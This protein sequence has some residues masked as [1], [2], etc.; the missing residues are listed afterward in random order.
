MISY[1]EVDSKLCYH[2]WYLLVCLPVKGNFLVLKLET[3]CPNASFVLVSVSLDHAGLDKYSDLLNSCCVRMKVLDAKSTHWCHWILPLKPL[4]YTVWNSVIYFVAKEMSN[5]HCCQP[6]QPDPQPC[7]H[8]KTNQHCHLSFVSI[9]ILTPNI[10]FKFITNK[11]VLYYSVWLL[12]KLIP[13][14]GSNL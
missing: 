2:H 1:V 14:Q 10:N 8:Q 4:M 12:L 3:K 13:T 9:N 6:K 7:R 11:Y 5:S